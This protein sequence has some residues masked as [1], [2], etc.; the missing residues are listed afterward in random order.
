MGSSK[1]YWPLSSVDNNIILGTKLGIPYG[2]IISTTG[3]KNMSN[4]ALQFSGTGSYIDA[5][6]FTKECL[7]FPDKCTN[8]LTISFMASFDSNAINWQNVKILDTVGDQ[9][10]SAGLA[11]YV[12]RQYLYFGVS[13]AHQSWTGKVSIVG[14]QAWRHYI[15]RWNQSGLNI[16]INGQVKDTK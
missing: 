3:V 5:G 7:T 16:Y 6:N 13:Q 10:N 14:D 9:S 11:V 2:K 15:M 4:T 12:D 1:Y 8:G